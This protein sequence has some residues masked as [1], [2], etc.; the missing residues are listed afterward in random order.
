MRT[1]RFVTGARLVGEAIYRRLTTPR[2]MLRGGEE[3]QNYGF[4]LSD[5]IGSVTTSA[6]AA[7]LPGRIEAEI[8]KDARILSVSVT[9]VPTTVGPS[10]SWDI[11]IGAETQD[12]PFTLVVAVDDVNI[13]LVGPGT[14]RCCS[15]QCY[16]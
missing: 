15:T 1:G 16:T 14:V 2:G 8:T 4:D 13:E 6:D 3:E 10:T 5:L 11:T 7:S 12:G 9:V